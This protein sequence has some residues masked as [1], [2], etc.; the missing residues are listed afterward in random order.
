MP[1]LSVIYGKD[2]HHAID[3]TQAILDNYV[4]DDI[5]FLPHHVDFNSIKYD[6]HV[7][8]IVSNTKKCSFFVDSAL[9]G[10]AL[11]QS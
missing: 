11:S 7:L 10:T 6:P 4:T 1:I 8:A 2:Q 3:L 5:L 9:S